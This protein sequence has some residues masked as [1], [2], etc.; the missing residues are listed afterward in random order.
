[1][2][3]GRG[4]KLPTGH[5]RA[6]IDY[7][8]AVW[9]FKQL[10]KLVYSDQIFRVKQPLEIK[11]KQLQALLNRTLLFI[12]TFPQ[13]Y[14]NIIHSMFELI[15]NRLL[16]LRNMNE[17]GR[18]LRENLSALSE[19]YLFKSVH[20]YLDAFESRRGEEFNTLTK[21]Q[22]PPPL[23]FS[24]LLRS[25]VVAE[26]NAAEPGSGGACSVQRDDSGHGENTPGNRGHACDRRRSAF[27]SCRRRGLKGREFG[28][29]SGHR[30]VRRVD[31]ARLEVISAFLRLRL[32][33]RVRSSY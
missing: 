6:A 23:E 22:L 8:T 10:Y 7:Y 27:G 15:Q 3:L 1:M 17:I 26:M 32:Q 24:F 29:W 16:V 13:E 28:R 14:Q 4:L 33:R 2:P 30:G 21:L 25:D 19:L 12:P 20:S 18:E 9:L 31:F 5:Q 11:V